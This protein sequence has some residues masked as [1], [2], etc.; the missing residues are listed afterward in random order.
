M[1]LR[2]SEGFLR[3]DEGTKTRFGSS[4]SR[5]IDGERHLH[6]RDPTVLELVVVKLIDP[7]KL[8]RAR[9][10]GSRCVFKVHLQIQSSS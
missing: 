2:G 7:G 1:F 4:T 5:G 3:L 6:E 10:Y 8:K 9:L